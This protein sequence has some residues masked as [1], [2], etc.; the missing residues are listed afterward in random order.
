MEQIIFSKRPEGLPDVETFLFQ[1]A[2]L[3][4]LQEGDVHL[5][6]LYISVDPYMRGRM[7]NQKSYIAPFEVGKP[8]DGGVIAEVIESKGSKLTKGDI[9][10]GNLPWQTE[11][12]TKERYLQKV[13]PNLAPVTAYLGV[14]GLTGLTAY[15]GL[16]DIG[17]PKP[18][19]TVVVS[20]GAGAVGS[21]VGQI[22]KIKGTRAVG[23]AG[24]QEKCQFLTE[25]LGFDA[26]VNYKDEDFYNQLKAATPD[27]V[28]VYFDNVGGVVSDKVMLRINTKARIPL[29]GQIA[30]YNLKKLDVGPR[31]QSFLVINS[32]LMQGF[33]V[34]DYQDR[35]NEGMKELTQWLKSGHLKYRET[36]VEGF[37]NIP[38]AFLGLFKGENIGKYL[39]KI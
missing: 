11:I 22:A 6:S 25:E 7:S 30:L 32:A 21:T 39:V 31:M 2:S 1:E 26:A 36:I 17:K 3:P 13:D 35:F 4:E 37:E 15:F 16:L 12:V 23:I 5:K 33:I 34:T 8:I 18:G 38:N 14:L 10:L 19:E 20:G 29:C 9:V 24:S 28:D 27:G